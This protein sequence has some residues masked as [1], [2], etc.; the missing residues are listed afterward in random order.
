M[1]TDKKKN[2]LLKAL[3][4]NKRSKE[5]DIEETIEFCDILN[6][7]APDH[8]LNPKDIQVFIQQAIESLILDF[9]DTLKNDLIHKLMEKQL[10]ALIEDCID[11]SYLIG[12]LLDY[13]ITLADSRIKSNMLVLIETIFEELDFVD[14]QLVELCLTSQKLYF[15]FEK[16]KFIHLLSSYFEDITGLINVQTVKKAFHVSIGQFKQCWNKNLDSI[17]INTY[18]IP[19]F[20]N[21]TQYFHQ[22]IIDFISFMV[23]KPLFLENCFN[24]LLLKLSSTETHTRYL[25]LIIYLIVQNRTEF[26]TSLN[27][28]RVFNSNFKE[29]IHNRFSDSDA[30]IRQIA[31]FSTP[32]VY[33]T[34]FKSCC[35]L[36]KSS[37]SED[38][39][40][41]LIYLSNYL[42]QL[43]VSK[44]LDNDQLQKY[45]YLISQIGSRV[46]DIDISV[47]Q[48]AIDVLIDFCQFS[49]D[50]SSELTSFIIDSICLVYKINCIVCHAKVN[51]FLN[52]FS[53][54]SLV[55]QSTNQSWFLH[56]LKTINKYKS[57]LRLSIEQPENRPTMFLSIFKNDKLDNCIEDILPWF[58]DIFLNKQVD[59]N[60]KMLDSMDIQFAA[61]GMHLMRLFHSH[62]KVAITLNH[63]E[64]VKYC[65]LDRS[66]L[67]LQQDN[68]SRLILIKR[69]ALESKN[70]ED[71]QA[72][73]H[74]AES[75][76]LN[77]KY[78]TLIQAVCSAVDI[79]I[80][81]PSYILYYSIKFQKIDLI[82]I[83]D[84]LHLTLNWL[85]NNNNTP[86]C[87]KIAY[88]AIMLNQ[89]LAK[90]FIKFAFQ[91]L[92]QEQHLQEC[93][94]FLIKLA[95]IPSVLVLMGIDLY[96]SLAFMIQHKQ[97]YIRQKV[98]QTIS[99]LLR[100]GKLNTNYLAILYLSA[101]EPD[102]DL[103]NTAKTILLL[104]SKRGIFY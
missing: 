37:L 102:Q 43:F 88:R 54:F 33:W 31:Q 23:E 12:K 58:K 34:N 5:C 3:I 76:V 94:H 64:F 86:L 66:I 68:E 2:K 19:V 70:K 83:E 25:A 96:H 32:S 29:L 57:A 98:I 53:N 101:F 18:E 27:S 78:I 59:Y 103:K 104:F 90:F 93:C 24:L 99:K 60:I 95:S 10:I 87:Y 81:Q 50:Q 67:D 65:G 30:T 97:F 72:I 52:G 91:Q 45:I 40:L 84:Y 56:H 9:D 7:L 74:M 71:K 75:S 85:S 28:T 69:F 21:F 8:G 92:I 63:L 1:D 16:P 42:K 51:S 79:P 48:I 6:T 49:V 77:H 44:A 61:I 100:L 46:V 39:V 14:N 11:K 13:F 89:S 17:F 38:R 73:L 55:L 82:K 62:Y 15:I 36:L 22:S 4:T 41:C 20:Y 80:D 47:R 35:I 26:Y